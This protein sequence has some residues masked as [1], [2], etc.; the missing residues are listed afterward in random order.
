MNKVID[1]RSDTVTLP[2]DSMYKA[3]ADA[4]LGDDVLGDDPTVKKME[5]NAAKLIG[6]EAALFVPSGTMGNLISIMVHCPRGTEIILGNKAHTF[7]YE[8][9]GISAFGGIHS[10]QIDNLPDGTMKIDDIRTILKKMLKRDDVSHSYLFR[11]IDKLIPNLSHKNIELRRKSVKALGW[12]GDKSLLPVYKVFLTSNNS[13]IRISCLK[14]F[15][16]IAAIE[17]Y[18]SIHNCISEVVD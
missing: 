6:K 16:K 7:V 15:V 3:M 14:I 17:K 5:L 9:G 4:V 2:T 1:L 8:A 10:H 13:I 18:N 12:F 11:V